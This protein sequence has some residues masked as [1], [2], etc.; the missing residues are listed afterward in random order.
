LKSTALP[1]TEKSSRLPHAKAI[2]ASGSRKGPPRNPAEAIS[3]IRPDAPRRRVDRARQADDLL[4]LNV[5]ELR[6]EQRIDAQAFVEIRG[7]GA[8]LSARNVELASEI[9]VVEIGQDHAAHL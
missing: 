5:E 3:G 7:V 2:V 1:P 8:R 9:V 4:R 6:L